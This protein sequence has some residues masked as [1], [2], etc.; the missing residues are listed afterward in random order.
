MWCI[1]ALKSDIWWKQFLRFLLKI[2]WQIS[3]CL[4]CEVNQKFYRVTPKGPREESPSAPSSPLSLKSHLVCPVDDW[5]KHLKKNATTLEL[6]CET[7]IERSINLLISRNRNNKLPFAE[8]VALM[9]SWMCACNCVVSEHYAT[10]KDTCHVDFELMSVLYDTA[11][12]C[13]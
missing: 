8:L 11:Q 5:I 3:R 13:R 2:S 10:A 6:G 9:R 1:L 7:E 4:N 12:E